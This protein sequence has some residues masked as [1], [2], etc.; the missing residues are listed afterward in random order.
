MEFCVVPQSMVKKPVTMRKETDG[1]ASQISFTITRNSAHHINVVSLI[2]VDIR[3]CK[4]L[5][6]PQQ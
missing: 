5:I 1:R 6:Y 3:Q 4:L 2:R